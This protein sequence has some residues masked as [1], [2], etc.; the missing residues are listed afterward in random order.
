MLKDSLTDDN[1]FTL[2]VCE[3]FQ[4]LFTYRVSEI[5]EPKIEHVLHV[6]YMESN[7]Q[8]CTNFLTINLF[9]FL[10][11]EIGKLRNGEKDD[12]TYNIFRVKFA[13]T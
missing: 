3:R 10:Q 9:F 12:L 13:G 5:S 8:I 1:R 11:Q 7:L 6:I 4:L 2:N